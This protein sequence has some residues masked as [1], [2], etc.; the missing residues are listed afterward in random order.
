LQSQRPTQLVNSPSAPR[1]DDTSAFQQQFDELTRLAGEICQMPAAMVQLSDENGR[2]IKSVYGT[3]LPSFQFDAAFYDAATTGQP[4]IISDAVSDIRFGDHPLVTEPPGIRFIA[5]VPLS[6]EG[7]IVL[8]TL[9][10]IDFHPRTI[11]AAQIHW[12]ESIARQMVFLIGSSRTATDLEAARRAAEA[13]ALAKSAFLANVSHEIRTPMSAIAGYA[14]LMLDPNQNDADRRDCLQIIRRNGRHLLELIDDV[15]DLARLESG[16]LTVEK[17]DCDL[18]RVLADIASLMTPR[19]AAKDVKLTLEL[20]EP[21][22]MPRYFRT[23]SLRLKQILV[24]LVGNAIKFTE[25]GHVTVRASHEFTAEGRGAMI[26]DVQDTGIGM[27]Q[28]EISRLYTPFTQG[29][30]SPTRRYSGTGLGLTLSRR[31]ARLL[32]GDISVRSK[33][34]EGSTFTLTIDSGGRDEHRGI[35]DLQMVDACKP[36]EVADPH[37]LPRIEGRILLADD[38]VDNQRLM[39]RILTRAGAE[40]VV[41]ENGR[42]AVN[43]ALHDDFH[44]VLMDMQM[45]QLDGYGAASELRRQG[46]A[47]PIIALT[48]HAGA[49]DREKCI[50]A[51]CDD[52]LSKP[53]ERL[54]LLQT[55]VA[56]ITGRKPRRPAQI[57]PRKPQVVGDGPL[58]STYADDPDMIEAIREFVDELP[59][60]TALLQKCLDESNLA[61]LEMAVHQLKGAGGGYGFDVVTEL[62]SAAE[63]C[64]KEG[65]QLPKIKSRVEE[66]M[67]TL[68][69]IEGFPQD[70]PSTD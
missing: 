12:L 36:D 38:G 68:Q 49:D 53:V 24:N 11:S 37:K 51:G 52:Y 25:R 58:V 59:R 22:A 31:L 41:A 67:K 34:G 26:F 42:D 57:P 5:A 48:A 19:A 21:T 15:L 63:Q 43:L 40:V 32:S 46:F 4:L 39:R 6:L 20:A 69:R 62:A 65:Q 33:P 23:D 8:G 29:D 18:A 64:I 54:L 35:C 14:D 9:G 2:W 61:R 30:G 10:V 56:H 7:G 17:G 50:R 16:R 1:A 70:G 45:P 66:L 28:Q 3:Q 13:A 27:N 55:L 44:V 60:H 47:R